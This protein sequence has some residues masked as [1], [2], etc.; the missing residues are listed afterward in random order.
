MFQNS[1]FWGLR[2]ISK[3]V[4][5]LAGPGA[6]P[7]IK[8][9]HICAANYMKHAHQRR[10][11]NSTNS[12][13][14]VLLKFC[15]QRSCG[16]FWFSEFLGQWNSG[17][18][19]VGLLYISLYSQTTSP[20]PKVP[21]LPCNHSKKEV[22]LS[23]LYRQGNEA[24]ERLHDLPDITQPASVRVRTGSWDPKFVGTAVKNRAR[25]QWGGGPCASAAPPQAPR[26][27]P[28]FLL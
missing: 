5:S 9:C 25:R 2:D 22:F 12:L 16:K 6:A 18:E 28:E 8:H 14:S 3:H 7:R 4:K 19:T 26:Q 24:S 1:E 10:G 23:L 21:F 20:F 27:Q 13:L 11:V 17:L 15:C